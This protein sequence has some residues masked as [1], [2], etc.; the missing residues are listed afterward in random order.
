MRAKLVAVALVLAAGSASAVAL[1][2]NGETINPTSQ[3]LAQAG[4][5][6]LDKG[7]ATAAIDQFETALAVDP[8][9]RLAYIGMARGYEK[10]SLPGKAVKFYR[11]ALLLE[12]NDL[13]ALEGQGNALV[14]RGAVTRAQANLARIRQLCKGECSQAQRLS[15]VIAKGPPK[16]QTAAAAPAETVAPKK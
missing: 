14:E 10:L 4:Y 3:R 7:Q 5:A 11:E 6:A 15:A 13:D 12:P 2:Q 8:R 9:N 16:T 1:G